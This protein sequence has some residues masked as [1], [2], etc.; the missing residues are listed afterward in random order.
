MTLVYFNHNICLR[1][2]GCFGEA[3][4]QTEFH[5]LSFVTFLYVAYLLLSDYWK[6]AIKSL[7]QMVVVIGCGGY[8]WR[9]LLSFDMYSKTLESAA[10]WSWL[11]VFNWWKLV[12]GS[13]IRGL[14]IISKR[15]ENMINDRGVM[16]LKRLI[17]KSVNNPSCTVLVTEHCVAARVTQTDNVILSRTYR[18]GRFSSPISVECLVKG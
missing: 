12:H 6:L 16:G 17:Q 7:E 1:N 5:S 14:W 11:C 18:N 9:V 8:W 2:G 13:V 3:T 10:Q 15:N 4:S